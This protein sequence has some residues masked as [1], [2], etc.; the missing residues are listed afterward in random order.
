VTVQTF[1]INIEAAV[2]D[3]LCDRLR[4]TR[5]PDELDGAGWDY[6]MNGSVLRSFV[7]T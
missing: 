4:G 1:E 7:Y 5:R 3:D 2:L 6:G